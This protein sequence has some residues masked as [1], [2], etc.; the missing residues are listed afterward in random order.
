MEL[1]EKLLQA[2]LEAGLS[3]RALCGDTITRN[4]LSRIEHGAARPSMDTLR[5]LAERLGKPIGYFLEDGPASPNPGVLARARACFAAGEFAGVLAALTEYRAPDPDVD[6]ERGLLEHLSCLALC[7]EAAEGGQAPYA[8]EL[9]AR[10]NACRTLYRVPALEREA[11]LLAYGLTGAAARTLEED[12]PED[13]RELLLRAEAALDR[14]D[15]SRAEALLNAAGERES[16][17]WNLLRGQVYL[18]QEAWLPAAECF[19]R[20]EGAFP[21]RVLPLLEQCYREAGDYKMAYLYACKQR[22]T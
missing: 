8:R 20:A 9:L 4:M 3:Q 21:R 18:A 15:F 16:P 13:D 11:V 14:G 22:Q 1:G 10:A 17:R 12:L 2:R 19:R 6:S 7:R 5:V